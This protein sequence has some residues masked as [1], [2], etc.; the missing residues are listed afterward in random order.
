MRVWFARAEAD[1]PAWWRAD[2]DPILG[3]A[4]RL[5]YGDPSRH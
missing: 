4:L 5:I 2:S 1:A 3:R